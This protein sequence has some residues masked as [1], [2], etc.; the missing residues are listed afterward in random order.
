M[1]KHWSCCGSSSRLS[2]LLSL[3]LPPPPP[4]PPAARCFWSFRLLLVPLHR[5]WMSP[6]Y[7]LRPTHPPP[8]PRAGVHPLSRSFVGR[9]RGWCRV[10]DWLNEFSLT[11]TWAR[12][13]PFLA[14]LTVVLRLFLYVSP[15]RQCPSEQSLYG[16]FSL[17]VRVLHWCP[18]FLG[19]P[20][21]TSART[22]HLAVASVLAAF[23]LWPLLR[24]GGLTGCTCAQTNLP[25]NRLQASGR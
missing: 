18:P 6:D 17:S 11:S 13:S 16:L 12:P 3:S 9:S 7:S 23:Y 14:P 21:P 5:P 2:L 4:S 24:P 22:R 10:E 19:G 15:V 25:H 20:H 1:C 8:P